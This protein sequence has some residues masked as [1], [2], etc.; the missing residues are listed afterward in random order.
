MLTPGGRRGRGVI[1][2]GCG[3]GSKRFACGRSTGDDD[4]TISSVSPVLNFRSSNW[5]IVKRH[6]PISPI[7]TRGTPV[8][9]LS[10]S[11]RRAT[12]VGVARVPRHA[13][14]SRTLARTTFPPSTPGTRPRLFSVSSL[15]SAKLFSLSSVVV[16]HISP[17]RSTRVHI[18]RGLQLAQFFR[19]FHIFFPAETLGEILL[20]LICGSGSGGGSSSGVQTPRSL[21]VFVIVRVI[22]SG[23]RPTT[24]SPSSI[25]LQIISRRITIVN[26]VPRPGRRRQTVELVAV[27]VTTE[28]ATLLILS[29]SVP[30]GGRVVRVLAS[31]RP[32]R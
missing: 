21:T 6:R 31:P 18:E 10:R 15:T 11:G 5:L 2:A 24:G 16:V 1:S 26:V 12:V 7:F 23:A 30:S 25:I 3:R 28:V 19:L 22:C 14:T 27:L 29:I 4:G 17:V 13:A 9:V 32:R 20:Q 8:T